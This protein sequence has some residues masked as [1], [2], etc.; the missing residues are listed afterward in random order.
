MGRPGPSLPSLQSSSSSLPGGSSGTSFSLS[1]WLGLAPMRPS[2][3]WQTF[4]WAMACHGE[5]GKKS[6]PHGQ[7]Y[8]VSNAGNISTKSW[9]QC[10]LLLVNPMNGSLGSNQPTDTNLPTPLSIINFNSWLNFG[11]VPSA[12]EV[13][14][15]VNMI[16]TAFILWPLDDDH[17]CDSLHLPTVLTGLE[18]L[19]GALVKCSV[20]LK[21]L[22]ISCHVHF[23]DLTR[24]VYWC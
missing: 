18:H 5:W 19:E 17:D 13:F 22:V 11:S 8:S 21:V 4:G 2:F 9:N 3:A 16:V 6:I 7:A 15:V 20:S 1:S 23:I 14:Q 24:I 12:N 10:R